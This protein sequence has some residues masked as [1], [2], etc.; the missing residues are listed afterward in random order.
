VSLNCGG[1]TP[2]TIYACR[3]R[4][5]LCVLKHSTY[6]LYADVISKIFAAFTDED[7]QGG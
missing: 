3:Y 6:I 4:V 2:S 7:S 1:N 5:E